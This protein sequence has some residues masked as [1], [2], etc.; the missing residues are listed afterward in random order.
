[1]TLNMFGSLK[2]MELKM[3]L[4]ECHTSRRV[5][6]LNRVAAANGLCFGQTAKWTATAA[7][8]SPGLAA[9]TTSASG[10]TWAP[11]RGPNVTSTPKPQTGSQAKLLTR[12]RALQ[13]RW[14]R[15]R[16]RAEAPPPQ[17]VNWS[18]WDLRTHLRTPV[19]KKLDP[20]CS[21]AAP[22]PASVSNCEGYLSYKNLPQ[23][24]CSKLDQWALCGIGDGRVYG[25]GYGCTFK[26]Y[27]DQ[28]YCK[29]LNSGNECNQFQ[30]KNS[31]KS[32]MVATTKS[33]F[34]VADNKVNVALGFFAVIGG[35]A[36]LYNAV[37]MVSKY[38]CEPKKWTPIGEEPDVWRMNTI[39]IPWIILNQLSEV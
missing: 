39:K 7:Q 24:W 5:K 9:E 30:L 34:S 25:S 23:D 4:L 22:S 37:Q 19:L 29:P 13:K 14:Q 15:A 8:R 35:C 12:L 21:H 18:V 28:N 3:Q 26:R 6:S 11:M 16:Q 1:M 32:M 2:Q 31:E 38:A 33:S 20:S 17:C 36:I 10:T 27:N